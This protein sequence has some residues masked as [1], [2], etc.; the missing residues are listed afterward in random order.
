MNNMT[1]EE[2]ERLAYISGDTRTAQLLAQ[3]LDKDNDRVEDLEDEVKRLEYDI[4]EMASRFDDI[5]RIASQ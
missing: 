3:A 2:Q 1:L 5:R 4:E